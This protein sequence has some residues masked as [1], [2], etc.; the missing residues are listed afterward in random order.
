M[1]AINNIQNNITNNVTGTGEIRSLEASLGRLESTLRRS[2]SSFTRTARSAARTEKEIGKLSKVT[3]QLNTG[4]KAFLTFNISRALTNMAAAAVDTINEFQRL[5]RV[6]EVTTGQSA[7]KVAESFRVLATVAADLPES[8]TEVVQSFVRLNNLGLDN[9]ADALRDFSNLSAG[10]GR[11]LG[12][13]IEAVADSATFEFERLKE[14]FGIIARQTDE[15]IKFTFQGTTTEV[16]KTAAA[17]QNYLRGIAQAKFADAATRQNETLKASFG[18]LGDAINQTIRLIDTKVGFS[19]GLATLARLAATN[20]RI[21]TNTAGIEDLESKLSNLRETLF[22]VNEESAQILSDGFF[23]RN[24]AFRGLVQI[25]EGTKEYDN[26]LN[27]LGNTAVETS[28][29]IALIE[30]KIASLRKEQFELAA[31]DLSKGIVQQYAL[32]SAGITEEIAKLEGNDGPLAAFERQ[33]KIFVDGLT[34]ENKRLLELPKVIAA[35]DEARSLAAR[36]QDLLNDETARKTAE[37]LKNLVDTTQAEAT[38]ALI[39]YQSIITDINEA[40]VTKFINA[41]SAVSAANKQLLEDAIKFIGEAELNDGTIEAEIA[42]QKRY[43]RVEEVVEIFGQSLVD[44][45]GLIERLAADQL[46]LGRESLIL[47]LAQSE[48]ALL[49]PTESIFRRIN[50][51]ANRF[52]EQ[53]QPVV[54]ALQQNV[55]DDFLRNFTL[56]S[57][58]INNFAAFS[59]KLNETLR[60]ISTS[61]LNVDEGKFNAITN[62]IDRVLGGQ[63]SGV[64]DLSTLDQF[65][66]RIEAIAALQENE[67]SLTERGQAAI[68]NLR[69]QNA[70]EIVNLRQA[71]SDEFLRIIQNEKERE[72]ALEKSTTSQRVQ[73][74]LE[75]GRSL[76]SA[77][78]DQSETAFKLSQAFAASQVAIDLYKAISGIRASVSSFGPL[79]FAISAIQIG[80]LIA[81]FKG[82]I[83][84]IENRN[85]GDSSID[86]VSGG[87]TN[88]SSLRSQVRSSQTN[89]A[90]INV[91]VY[92]S[93]LDEGGLEDAIAEGARNALDND[94]LIIRSTD[95]R[96]F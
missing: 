60:N 89:A 55:L 93:I 88:F 5:S 80:S 69:A 59:D 44:Q 41:N 19:Q 61:G 95:V 94:K 1:A 65:N 38:Q 29:A 45:I 20:I 50:Q 34:D 21:V 35:I 77:F 74:A 9:S 63:S 78:Q 66:Q 42:F 87:G 79:G 85:I 39:R 86:G 67:F 51:I 18:N 76:L 90:S 40:N 3:K 2:N 47:E 52:R 68:A 28:E 30:T 43:E 62:F 72:F 23:T 82:Y 56:D 11:N 75:A 32:I 26:T 84:A 27:N 4:F 31:P 37:K 58:G 6:L 13:L 73:L 22:K 53:P 96:R 16:E 10:L 57:T 36:Q 15:T 17:V 92:G 54:N 8:V 12:R 14:E 7:E 70:R 48:A 71:Q 46:K 81:E 91:N 83:D 25:N 49:T 24:S 33:Y 64:A